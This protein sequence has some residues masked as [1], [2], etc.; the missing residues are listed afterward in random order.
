MNTLHSS[1][2]RGFPAILSSVITVF[3]LACFPI[4]KAQAAILAGGAL[5]GVQSGGTYDYTVTLTNLGSVSD[6]SINTFWYAWIP[7][8]NYLPVTPT[9]IASP[10][11]WVSTVTHA[12]A[13]DGYAIQWHTSTTGTDA[14][15]PGASFQFTFDMTNT[16]ASLAGNSVFYTNT[17]V[18]TSFVYSGAPLSGFS[19]QFVVQSVPEPTS[20][21]LIALGLLAILSIR[22]LLA[23][24]VKRKR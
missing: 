24:A 5:S 13:S 23:F 6:S 7:G 12:G 18:G 14:L 21:A 11:G 3:F 1:F 4:D 9:N 2:Q 10:V 20:V 15:A 22:P 8:Q 16:P 17:P 19:E